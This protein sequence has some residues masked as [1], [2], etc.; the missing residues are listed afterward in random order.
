L[1]T[2]K[3]FDCGKKKLEICQKS[4]RADFHLLFCP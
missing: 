2:H 3:W 1:N 4:K